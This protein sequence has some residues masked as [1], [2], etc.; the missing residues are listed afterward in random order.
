M[1][2]YECK[3]FVKRDGRDKE[4][5]SNELVP[6]DVIAIPDNCIMPCDM[7]LLSGQCIVNESML[8]GESVPVIKNSIKPIKEL[9]DPKQDSA[10]KF[11]LYSGTKVIQAREI[12][13]QRAYALV[14]RTGFVTTKGALVRDILYPRETKF[15]FYRDSLFF[16]FAM[17][18]VGIGGFCATLPKLIE[19]GTTTEKLIDKSLDL[20]TITV[21]PALPATMSVG[22]A[23]AI[24]RLKKSS[25][26]CISPPRVN[27]SG[28]IQ[29]MVFDKTGTLTEDGLQILGVRG[30]SGM[31]E[32]VVSWLGFSDSILNIL[33]NRERT[34]EDVENRASILNEAMACC[35]SITYIGTELIGD[36]LDIKM[37]ESTE[38]LLEEKFD[39]G[40]SMIP[41][42][43]IILAKVRPGMNI[44]CF[45]K[46]FSKQTL[47]S[48]RSEKLLKLN[49][50]VKEIY[51]L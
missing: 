45:T 40:N 31:L 23:F 32:D 14:T 16:V 7:V 10:K 51:E 22:V 27:V 20:I 48:F 26:F 24:A 50:E 4:M 34:Q 46:M 8:T 6:G 21:P 5:S 19:L 12:A 43:D 36:P 2:E 42:D 39:G 3:V 18:F 1:A 17:G 29:I 30:L 49:E 28:M 13:N 44:P 15:S 41:S 35:H 25:I 37:F 47:D 33:P 38:W 9:Y 11:T